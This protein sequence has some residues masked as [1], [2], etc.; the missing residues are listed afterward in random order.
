M[1]DCPIDEC[2]GSGFETI[3]ALRAHSNSIG[4]NWTDV[5]HQLEGDDLEEEDGESEEQSDKNH[6]SSESDESTD[7]D[8]SENLVG[9]AAEN[10][11]LDTD[12]MPT[13]EEYENQ[14]NENDDT[15]DSET[16]GPENLDGTETENENLGL[17]VPVDPTTV[18]TV[19]VLGVTVW[20]IMRTVHT[21][22]STE[23]EVQIE[24][25]DLGTSESVEPENISKG[26]NR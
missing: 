5:T 22:K 24:S 23:D 6:E 7:P 4:H 9:S 12:D 8:G 15:G 16:S 17:S 2:D 3:H 21:E 10:E 20:L 14:H 13:Q 1:I 26:L 11:N 18:A 19:V 25:Q